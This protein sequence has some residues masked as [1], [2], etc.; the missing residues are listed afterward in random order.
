M[1]FEYNF[2]IIIIASLHTRARAAIRINSD[3]AAALLTT[4]LPREQPPPNGNK[5]LY[6][7]RFLF[8]NCVLNISEFLLPFIIHSCI[9]KVFICVT[10][11]FPFFFWV[12]NEIKSSM[13]Q[14]IQCK[15]QNCSRSQF[16]KYN[17]SIKQFSSGLNAVFLIK[18]AV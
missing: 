5:L 4:L 9:F 16:G 3:C 2:I 6:E 18:N 17:A 14:Y 7:A 15:S 12:P 11:G 13:I 10:F 8:V 1:I